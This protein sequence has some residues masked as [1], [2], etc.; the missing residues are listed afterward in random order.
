MSI[1]DELKG[2]YIIPQGINGSDSSFDN[3]TAINNA[4]NAANAAGGGTVYL[5]AGTYYVTGT[6]TAS[7]GCISLKSNVTLKGDGMGV[8]TIKVVDGNTQAITGVVRTPSGEKTS[9]VTIMDL[10]IDGND[11]NKSGGD[12]N[13]C[14]FCGVTPLI[15]VTG[16]TEAAGTATFTTADSSDIGDTFHVFDVEEDGTLPTQYAQLDLTVDDRPTGTTFTVTGITGSPA[17][18]TDD[19]WVFPTSFANAYDEDITLIRV[20]VTDSNTYGF[21][22]HQWVKRI[23]FTDCHAHDTTL[24]GFVLDG[25]EDLVIKGCTSYNNARH[26]FNFVTGTRNS[27]IDSCVA[28]NNTD[29][30]FSIQRGSDTKPWCKNNIIANSLSYGNLKEGIRLRMTKNAT[31]T[32]CRIYENERDGIQTDG[33]K[34]STI[35]GND[36][37]DNGQAA[38]NTYDAVALIQEDDTAVSGNTFGSTS[39]IVKDNTIYS[40]SAS[41]QHRYGIYETDDAS[42]SNVSRG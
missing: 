27:I 1:F 40:T 39:V 4:I 31:I 35:V 12:V 32:G 36:I 8:T 3:R 22:P 37:Y 6:G 34:N 20:E 26:G 42:N 19:V 41:L 18:V 2:N 16:I 33:L 13:A 15:L 29:N 9:N 30:G 25:C 10:T 21:D 5:P 14:F 28:Y 38:T 24:D 11:T 23:R 7:D 17:D